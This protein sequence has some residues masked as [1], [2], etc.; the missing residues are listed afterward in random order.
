MVMVIA[1]AICVHGL[2]QWA[3]L[4]INW[5]HDILSLYI[6]QYTWIE[7]RVYQNRFLKTRNEIMKNQSVSPWNEF[8]QV[9]QLTQM[10]SSLQYCK[11]YLYVILLHCIYELFSC[12]I[13]VSLNMYSFCYFLHASLVNVHV[14]KV[15]LHW[16]MPGIVNKILNI[17]TVLFLWFFTTYVFYFSSNGSV[18][19]KEII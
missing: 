14:I 3:L 2:L 11:Y 7:Q 5:I 6:T 1:T 4:N 19:H 15:F 16:C 12:F 18:R 8:L 10:I 17:V 9:L 13:L